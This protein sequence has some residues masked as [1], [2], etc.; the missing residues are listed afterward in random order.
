MSIIERLPTDINNHILEF[1][2][3]PKIMM[4][5]NY[6]VYIKDEIDEN[7]IFK[8]RG[9]YRVEV[10]LDSYNQKYKTFYGIPEEELKKKFKNDKQTITL[11]KKIS[12]DNKV[13]RDDLC[14]C[15]DYEFTYE[16]FMLLA[17]TL[18]TI[19]LNRENI[20]QL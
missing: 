20:C 11:F 18:K 16:E 10:Q 8:Q 17:P 12:I 7:E 9:L 4:K 13:I 3:P 6:A 2:T 1:L 15:D 5:F 19:R 14:C